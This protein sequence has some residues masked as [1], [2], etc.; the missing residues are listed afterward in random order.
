MP[1]F[2]RPQCSVKYDVGDRTLG[3]SARES[4]GIVTEFHNA[5]IVFT[6]YGC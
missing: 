6:H 5:C 1:T 3:I 4:R 2:Y